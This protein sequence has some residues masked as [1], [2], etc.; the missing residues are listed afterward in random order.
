MTVRVVGEIVPKGQNRPADDH[1][2]SIHQHNFAAD[3]HDRSKTLKTC[4][5]HV[6]PLKHEE[7]HRLRELCESSTAEQKEMAE[8][9]EQ[10]PGMT[11]R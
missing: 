7:E 11:K 3:L 2:T 8:R 9:L 4:H 5:T 10:V 6:L 1:S